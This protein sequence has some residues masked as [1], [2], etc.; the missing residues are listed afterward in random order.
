MSTVAS[1]ASN[2]ALWFAVGGGPIAWSVDTLAAIAIDHDF[3]V[4]GARP[5]GAVATALLLGVSV[6]AVT[7]TVFAGL[8]GWR[9]VT[10]LG[11]DTGV[12][13]TDVDRRRFMARF[14]MVISALMLFAIVLRMITV[15]FL[16]PAAC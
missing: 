14:G 5:S 10:A 8:A 4:H 9:T 11:E 12:G 7:V 2:R 3:C 1:Q 6:C 16:S 13:D 15:L